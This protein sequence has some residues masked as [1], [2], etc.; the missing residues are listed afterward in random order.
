MVHGQLFHLAKVA[1]IIVRMFFSYVSI[2]PRGLFHHR[3]EGV[4]FPWLP[5]ICGPLIVLLSGEFLRLYLN[6]LFCI[7]LVCATAVALSG[8][9]E[10]MVIGGL[11][12]QE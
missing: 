7:I 5:R 1:I 6:F 3:Q 9:D 8:G 12:E 4:R 10:N 11:T 2:R